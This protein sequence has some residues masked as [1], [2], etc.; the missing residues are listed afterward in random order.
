MVGIYYNEI[1]WRGAF[2]IEGSYSD[3]NWDI[4]SPWGPWPSNTPNSQLK[5]FVPSGKALITL[6]ES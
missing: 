1:S 5:G 3:E 2:S 6:K 4:I